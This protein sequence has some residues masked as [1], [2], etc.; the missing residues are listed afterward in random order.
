MGVLSL[1]LP[2][3]LPFSSVLSRSSCSFQAGEPLS[4]KPDFA[5]DTV[6]LTRFSA[7]HKKQR[8]GLP[9]AAKVLSYVLAAGMVYTPTAPAF[10]S[11]PA[12]SSSPA[13][14]KNPPQERSLGAEG[15][16]ENKIWGYGV[17][18]TDAT[19]RAQVDALCK[20]KV[21]ADGRQSPV[22]RWQYNGENYL[23]G[24]VLECG[25]TQHLERAKGETAPVIEK[26]TKTQAAACQ[27]RLYS[28]LL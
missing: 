24:H 10:A 12:V 26:Q 27:F 13:P 28:K 8:K 9:A 19:P 21:E 25:V 6:S 15:K 20:E 18:A 23:K 17:L 22:P 5:Q 4:F 7:Q 1:G 14:P 11:A 16:K 2:P 3:A